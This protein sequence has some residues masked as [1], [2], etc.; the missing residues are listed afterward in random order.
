MKDQPRNADSLIK[1]TVI[2]RNVMKEFFRNIGIIDSE[3]L[4]TN[5]ENEYCSIL[6]HSWLVIESI[7]FTRLHSGHTKKQ[8]YYPDESFLKVNEDNLLNYYK[9][10][11]SL[12]DPQLVARSSHSILQK[13]LDSAA[14]LEK[15][16]IDENEMAGLF[17]LLLLRNV[18]KRINLIDKR[19]AVDM[20]NRI[21]KELGF[22]YKNSYTDIA[23]RLGQLILCLE[24]IEETDKSLDELAL[25]VQLQYKNSS[26]N[27]YKYYVRG[28][29]NN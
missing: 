23:E 28:Q 6:L 18:A 19:K 14:L 9:S 27:G 5:I 15:L 4:G 24:D 26:L 8:L 7:F 20:Q 17:V 13:V 3:L 1:A 10:N 11:Q 2:E 29:I 12:M 22:Y 25:I 16:E 21:F